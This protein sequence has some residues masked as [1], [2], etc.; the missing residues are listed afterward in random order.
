MQVELSAEQKAAE[1]AKNKGN[2]AYKSRDFPSA[3]SHYTVAM[4]ADP[5]NMVYPTN[6]AAAYYEAGQYEK[7]I[8][9]CNKAIEVGR[10]VFADYKQIAK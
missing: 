8:E 2:E 1:Q 7:C 9:D 3:I 10:S 4:E 5:K 6:R